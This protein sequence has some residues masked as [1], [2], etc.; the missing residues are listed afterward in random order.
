LQK[1]RLISDDVGISHGIPR[2]ENPRSGP[3]LS[4]F[5]NFYRHLAAAGMPIA[6]PGKRGQL[7]S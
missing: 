7:V 4:D 5:L 3:S 6:I 2:S 1:S